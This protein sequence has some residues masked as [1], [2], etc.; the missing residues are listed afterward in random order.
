MD[1]SLKNHIKLT[2]QRDLPSLYSARTR[3]YLCLFKNHLMSYVPS[4][5][6][7][8]SLSSAMFIYLRIFVY[9]TSLV[10]MSSPSSV[11]MRPISS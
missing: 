5:C 1:L 2:M 6:A 3:N 10:K 9:T 7:A 8:L 11:A 4:S